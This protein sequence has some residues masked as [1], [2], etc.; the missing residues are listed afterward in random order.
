MIDHVTEF[1]IHSSLCTF[2]RDFQPDSTASVERVVNFPFPFRF[3]KILPS[4]NDDLA[5]M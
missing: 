3:M 4:E 1:S 2:Y 5:N